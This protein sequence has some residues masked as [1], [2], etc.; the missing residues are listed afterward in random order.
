MLDADGVAAKLPP[1]EL[2]MWVRANVVHVLESCPLVLKHWKKNQFPEDAERILFR[3]VG[4]ALEGLAKNIKAEILS[5]KGKDASQKELFHYINRNSMNWNALSPLWIGEP[6]SD[7]RNAAVKLRWSDASLLGQAF[8]FI[9]QPQAERWSRLVP[10]AH[11]LAVLHRRTLV[12][13]AT[14]NIMKGSLRAIEIAGEKWA[15]PEDIALARSLINTMPQSRYVL[16]AHPEAKPF[17]TALQKNM[18]ALVAVHMGLDMM[19]PFYKMI[20]LGQVD[21]LRNEATIVLPDLGIVDF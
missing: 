3:Y 8:H 6:G 15:R 11:S 14:H 9:S 10:Y 1:E 20:L 12:D 18:D 16:I 4:E 21:T 7:L 13:W 5:G 17:S 19:S 2:D